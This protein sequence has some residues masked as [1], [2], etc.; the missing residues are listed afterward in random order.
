MPATGIAD[1]MNIL[2]KAIRKAE[3]ALTVRRLCLLLAVIYIL[4]LIPLFLIGRYD[5]ASADDFSEG[6]LAY[7]ALQ[8]GGSFFSAVGAAF[9]HAVHDYLHWMG[10]FSSTFIM[11][12]HPGVFGEGLYSLTPVILIGSYTAG[13]LV[14]F[15]ALFGKVFGASRALSGC[16]A[17]LVLMMTI[18]NMVGVGV[19]EAFYW[20]CGGSNYTF[21]FGIALLY[22]GLMIRL[23]AKTPAGRAADGIV[24]AVTA[25]L[26][27]FVG[28]GNY[29]TA[30]TVAV[31]LAAAPVFSRLT[32]GKK[33][34]PVRGKPF[35]AYDRLILPAAAFYAGFLMNCLSPGNATREEISTGMS[36][37]KAILT[38]L[39]YF[40]DYCVS[41]WTGWAVL[42]GFLLLIP[43][44][45]KAA[46]EPDF[47]FRYPLLVLLFGYGIVS[48]NITPPL[49]A[50]GNIEAGRLRA[51]IFMQYVPV[52]ALCEFYA[53]G[54]VMKRYA[55][56][57]GAPKEHV[58]GTRA[59]LALCAF[60]L[61]GSSLCVKVDPY[62]YTTSAAVEDLMNGSAAAY[63]EAMEERFAVLRDDTVKD[64]VFEQL[65]AEPVLL[66]FEDMTGDPEHWKNKAVSRY[67]GK[68]SVVVLGRQ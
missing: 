21:F 67:Y 1:K 28:G 4:L 40:F 17:L 2:K 7:M 55:V 56:R 20:F 37:V 6:Y 58:P 15:I 65:P 23:W 46:E 18:E 32:L 59:F 3:E 49:F 22:L 36:A 26:G 27:F 52:M 53:V 33:E 13:I 5:Y 16:I 66:F 39:Y 68:D 31:I 50:V 42:A 61:F 60:I 44:F 12:I 9:S 11:A 38:S 19:N 8:Q 54:Y 29:M 41:D 24:C 30:L 43:F 57:T 63:G 47:A 45:M 48:A 10:Y 25:F 14:L 35:H 34:K 51:L 62:F 64:A